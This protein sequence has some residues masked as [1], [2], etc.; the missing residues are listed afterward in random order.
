MNVRMCGGCGTRAQTS[1]THTHTHTHTQDLSRLGVTRLGDQTKLRLWAKKT[2]D[3]YVR[4]Q[5][6]PRSPS[7]LRPGPRRAGQEAPTEAATTAQTVAANGPEALGDAEAGL[8]VSAVPQRGKVAPESW[9]SPSGSMGQAAGERESA[10][11]ASGSHHS[12]MSRDMAASLDRE[13]WFYRHS[14]INIFT[15]R[16]VSRHLGAVLDA[17][18]LLFLP[19]LFG[20]YLYLE[21]SGF[22]VRQA[23]GR[24][25]VLSSPDPSYPA[26]TACLLLRA[27]LRAIRTSRY[28]L[29][30]S[31]TGLRSYAL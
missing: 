4:Q 24:G 10:Q 31:S 30:S 15:G 8:R 18:G 19:L 22:F 23:T 6:Q 12:A 14:S 9:S 11:P 28:R 3:A 27:R 25:L 26:V 16:N 21:L 5:A 13:H 2:L 1:H 20:V 29:L 17:W 7:P